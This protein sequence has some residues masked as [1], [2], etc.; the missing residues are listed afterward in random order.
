MVINAARGG[1]IDEAALIEALDSGQCGGAAL[2]VFDPEP[3]AKDSPLR[4]HPKV[5]LT[6]HLGAST[7]EAQEAV[8]VDACK[9]LLAYLR[10]EGAE[11]AVNA[12]GL[13]MD[14][15]GRQKA[16]VDLASRMIALVR[17]SSGEPDLGS[18]R[19]TMRGE[20]LAGRADT[21]SRYA[22]A[23][24]LKGHLAQP[25]SLI[26]AAMIAEQR[27]I[28]VKT[29]IV[30]EQGDDRLSIDI[31][32]KGQNHKVEGAIY[33]DGQPRITHLDGYNMDMVPAG[34]MMLLTNADLPGRIG[35]VGKLF[36]DANVNIAEMVIGRKPAPG[37][38]GPVAMMIIKTDGVPPQKLI[39]TL[40]QADGILNVAQVDLPELR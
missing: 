30:P 2:D 4:K 28:D 26:N 3:L 11:G 36:G 40:R 27:R 35:M 37:G 16:F 32:S 10:G 29:I 15:T 7:L 14:L 31:V 5:V 1:I 33:A 17:A 34:H 39:D 12:S 6:P 23:Q 25:V 8:A 20:S 13:R 24:L 19:F 38:G 21:I 9:S 22:L 18:V